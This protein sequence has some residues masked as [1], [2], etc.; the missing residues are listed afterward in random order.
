M[1]NSQGPLF[2]HPMIIPVGMSVPIGTSVGMSTPVPVGTPI[3][4]LVP[5]A[6]GNQPAAG[7][8]RIR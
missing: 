6:A 8:V 2:A 1:N 7:Y 4:I 3:G 5:A